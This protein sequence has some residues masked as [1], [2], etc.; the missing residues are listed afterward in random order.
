MG[1]G[2]VSASGVVIT[3]PDALERRALVDRHTRAAMLVLV[4]GIGRVDGSAERREAVR[5]SRTDQRRRLGLRRGEVVPG[6]LL[7]RAYR[8]HD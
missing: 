4:V 3:V 5:L 2:R 8:L 1:S 6:V 7:E